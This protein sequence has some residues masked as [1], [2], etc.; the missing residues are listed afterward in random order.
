M[1]NRRMPVRTKLRERQAA[2]TRRRVLLPR[3]FYRRPA[4]RVAIDL[5]GC[6]V[7]RRLD[8][9]CLVGRIVETEAYVG[10]DDLACHAASGR[11][12]RN[13]VMFGPPGHAYVYFVYGMHHMLNVVCQPRGIPEAVL[14][15]ALE[16]RAGIEHMRARRRVRRDTE[17]ASGPGKVCRA[18]G[19]TRAQNGVDLRGAELW[20]EPGGLAS[21]E[22]VLRGPRI[23][24]DYAGADALR[25]L[26]FFIAANPH[27]SKPR[28]A[29]PPGETRSRRAGHPKRPGRRR[30]ATA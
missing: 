10:M 27:V 23:G 19:V 26:R 8:G 20:I 30:P 13:A 2:G 18:F 22:A 3:S 21:G 6:S 1:H 25:P 17:I 7:V 5:L 15:R 9:L 29:E 11:T 16:P 24:V 28:Q 14:V 12:E 4:D